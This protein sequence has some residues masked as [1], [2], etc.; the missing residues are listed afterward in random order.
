[1]RRIV[2]VCRTAMGESLRSAHALKNLDHVEL[3]GIVERTDDVFVNSVQV[4]NVHD[5]D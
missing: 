1:M 2:F 5:A 3:L 4:A